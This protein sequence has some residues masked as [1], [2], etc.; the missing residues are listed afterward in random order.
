MTILPL[1][2]CVTT[3]LEY[4]KMSG[5]SFPP[6]QTV[7]GDT[8]TL[9]SIYAKAG[10]LLVVDENDTEIAALA[11]DSISDAELDSVEADNRSSPVD[12]SSR[13]CGFW[14]FRGTCTTY[15][16]YGI[17]VNHF[18]EDSAGNKSTSLLGRMWTT[19]NRRAFV[20]FYKN[21]TVSGDGGKYL[22]SAAHEIGHGF[23]LHHEDGDGVKTIMNQTGVV[24]DSYVYE[25]SSTS[26]NHLKNH[27]A[28]CVFP[29]TGTFLSC[30]P[31][32]EDHVT[33]D[34]EE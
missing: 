17:V 26:L 25:F 34:C 31:D 27:P 22:R 5:T 12:P 7:D 23:N 4:D 32:H 20:N 10:K 6:E 9:S 29:G 28:H 1:L 21:S 15:Y 24:G 33:E 8:V 14:I 3:H 13:S 2:G 30:V 18:G 11:G 16:L 19:G